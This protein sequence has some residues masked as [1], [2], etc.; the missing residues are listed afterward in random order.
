[1]VGVIMP[2]GDRLRK[3]RTD[4]GLTQQELAMRAGLSVSVVAQ[5]EQGVNDD[6]RLSTL[7]ALARA[8]GV[9]INDLTGDEDEPAPPETEEPEQR[10]RRGRPRKPKSR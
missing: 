6:P 10:P 7:R 4:A 5:T 1:M 8:L 9:T 2:V 3:L